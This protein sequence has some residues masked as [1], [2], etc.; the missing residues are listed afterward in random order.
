MADGFFDLWEMWPQRLCPHLHLPLQAGTDRQLRRMARRCTVESYRS[1]VAEARAAIPDLVLTTDLIVGFPGESEEDF[2]QG[3]AFCQRDALRPGPHAFRFSARRG[4]A[5]AKFDG[6]LAKE[7]KKERSRRMHALVQ[8]SGRRER[9]RFVGA[10]R[11]V[12]WEADN[13]EL[14]DELGRVWT[15]F[16][17]NYL[18]VRTVAPPDMDLH[19]TISPVQLEGIH[20]DTLLGTIVRKSGDGPFTKASPELHGRMDG[21]R[22][23]TY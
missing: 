21:K 2:E 3:L 11:P 12:L 7:V 23:A 6:Q 5:A 1:L 4:T 13:G 19:R 8:E 9:E 17:D 14:T 22:W 16:T 20:A 10:V 15:G 18:R